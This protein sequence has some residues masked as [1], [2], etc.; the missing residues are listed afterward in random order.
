M[1]HEDTAGNYHR[2]MNVNMVSCFLLTRAVLPHMQRAGYGRTI[3]TASDSIQPPESSLSVYAASKGAVAAFTRSTATEA[4]PRVTANVVSP[5]L[6]RTD[7]TWNSGIAPDGSRPLFDKLV[8]RSCV[9]GHGLPRDDAHLMVFIASPEAEFITG[10]LF[11]VD[12]GA[13]FY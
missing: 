5:S 13:I 7:T 8:A 11:D 1:I 10:Q 6:M 9:K 12:C 2:V 4:G 3:K